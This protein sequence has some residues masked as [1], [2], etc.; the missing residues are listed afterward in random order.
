MS[1]P[2]LSYLQLINQNNISKKSKAELEH[3]KKEEAALM[4]NVKIKEFKE[5]KENPVAHAEFLRVSKLFKAIEKND[6]LFSGVI[7]RYCI[8]RA[9]CEDFQVKREEMYKTLLE[10]NDIATE[11]SVDKKYEVLNM[12]MKIQNQI[13]ALDKQVQ[14]KRKM[15]LDIE[16]ENIMTVAGALRTISKKPPKEEKTE[17][18]LYD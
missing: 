6:D 10:L 16:R 14:V 13:I 15:M 12:K 5:V 11:A 17:D 8:L 2:A 4:T 9:E 3:R 18:D 7:N 1:R